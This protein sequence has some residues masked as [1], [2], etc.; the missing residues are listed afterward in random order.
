MTQDTK[1]GDAELDELIDELKIGDRYIVR[2]NATGTFKIDST[3]YELGGMIGIE[4]L[5]EPSLE[6]SALT[7]DDVLSAAEFMTYLV[8]AEIRIDKRHLQ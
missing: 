7:Y 8:N 3:D 2:G 6:D 5:N 4:W 1:T